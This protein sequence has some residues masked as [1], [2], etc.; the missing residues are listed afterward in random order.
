MTYDEKRALSE[1]FDA[2]SHGHSRRVE[3]A[4]RLDPSGRKF[5]ETNVPGRKSYSRPCEERNGMHDVQSA[6]ETNIRN[7][8]AD[9]ARGH[10]A[11]V[12]RGACHG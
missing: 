5:A 2:P 12:P 11:S 4:T 9:V 10:S 6:T 7:S 8:H 1:L 3:M